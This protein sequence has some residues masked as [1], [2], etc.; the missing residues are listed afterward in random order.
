MDGVGA[1]SSIDGIDANSSIHGVG[2]DLSIYDLKW[3]VGTDSIV[4]SCH[5]FPVFRFMV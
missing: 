1:D 5:G 2:A 3:T 4:H